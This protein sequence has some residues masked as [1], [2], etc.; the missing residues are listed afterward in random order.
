MARFEK[1]RKIM[2]TLNLWIQMIGP[3]PTEWFESSIRLDNGVWMIGTGV[4]KSV[5]NGD[6]LFRQQ[7]GERV[8]KLFDT[9][10][11]AATNPF[12]TLISSSE[13]DRGSV[14]DRDLLCDV[15]DSKLRSVI[16]RFDSARFDSA[17]QANRGNN[18][19]GT[20]AGMT[21][22]F[23]HGICSEIYVD[24]AST[25]ITWCANNVYHE[26]MHNKSR[27]AANED[28]DWVHTR[29]GGGLAAANG[30][31]GT[32]LTQQTAVIMCGRL[33]IANRQLLDG[34]PP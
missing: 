27:W 29:G 17:L 2:P 20:V 30:G 5:A 31:E 25:N 9:T 7:L 15:C 13:A 21:A 34:L 12:D 24:D 23:A 6:G 32:G 33:V 1:T 14:K 8:W 28:P 22:N 3:E 16:K 4:K 10:R 19:N 26:W 11:R 18:P